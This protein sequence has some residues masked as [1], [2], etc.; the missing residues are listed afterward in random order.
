MPDAGGNTLRRVLATERAESQ[1]RFRP[2]VLRRRG[3]WREQIV[4]QV[5][6]VLGNLKALDPF[7]ERGSVSGPVLARHADL[8]VRLVSCFSRM[9]IGYEDHQLLVRLDILINWSEKMMLARPLL[10]IK[11][12]RN[13]SPR[14]E[15]VLAMGTKHRVED[16][17]FQLF[18][19]SSI[20]P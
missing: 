18:A 4:P 9:T 11:R 19:Q 17:R 2:R 13:S 7:A 3:I 1:V 20:T 16:S 15:A 14:A 12:P 5:A 6:G 10:K 8:Y